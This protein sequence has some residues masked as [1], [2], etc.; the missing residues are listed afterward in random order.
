MQSTSLS[1][2]KL[3]FLLFVCQIC[4]GKALL[5]HIRRSGF[6]LTLFQQTD[7]KKSV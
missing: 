3:I 7:D 2:D 1:R 6:S 5:T 4:A